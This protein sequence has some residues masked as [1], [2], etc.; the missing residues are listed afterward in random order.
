M[1][2]V[3][4]KKEIIRAFGQADH[5]QDHAHVQ[6][7]V[8]HHLASM[9]PS[10]ARP[11]L[12]E[13]GCGTGFLSQHLLERWPDSRLLCSDMALSMVQRCRAHLG[14]RQNVVY[15]VQDGEQPAI[16]PGSMDLIVASMVMQWF[17][18]PLGS[19]ASL[20]DLLRPGGC[21]AF[22][23][24]GPGTFRE[25]QVACADFGL[26]SGLVAY[27][28]A[29]AWQEAWPTPEL[30]CLEETEVTVDHPSGLAFLRALRAIGAHR[31]AAGYQPQSA[32]HLRR[33]LRHL[34]MGEGFAVRYQVLY[35]VFYKAG[36]AQFKEDAST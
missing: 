6:R 30:A 25:W 32:G 15:A 20:H 23:T 28:T 36:R 8:A 3:A 14:D 7:Q 5:Y 10:F 22:A 34:E 27:P 1:M 16:A 21:L 18:D 35:G 13:L 9:V 29:T 19:L 17:G 24:L 4:H 2:A 26:P 33:L 11:T 12:L 31:P